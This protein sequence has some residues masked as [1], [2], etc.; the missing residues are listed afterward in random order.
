MNFPEGRGI[1]VGGSPASDGESATTACPSVRGVSPHGQ[2]STLDGL[3]R[4]S[5]VVE[6]P[7]ATCSTGDLGHLQKK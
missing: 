3:T 5:I 1:S 7:D 4:P 2:P 6:G